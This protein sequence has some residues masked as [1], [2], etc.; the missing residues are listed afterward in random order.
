MLCVKGVT[1]CLFIPYSPLLICRWGLKP[2]DVLL[3][4]N[5]DLIEKAFNLV[6]INLSDSV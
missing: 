6:C 4:A 3:L 5:L 1:L 2:I